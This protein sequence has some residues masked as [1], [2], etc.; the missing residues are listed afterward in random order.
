MRH[1]LSALIGTLSHHRKLMSSLCVICSLDFVLDFSLY[2][3]ICMYKKNDNVY[4]SIHRSLCKST[5]TFPFRINSSVSTIQGGCIQYRPS[6]IVACRKQRILLD[7]KPQGQNEEC[8][9]CLI[10]RHYN[11]SGGAYGPF[12]TWNFGRPKIYRIHTKY[13]YISSYTRFQAPLP[14][15]KLH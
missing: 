14:S 9:H 2:L 15:S 5:G 4:M 10:T 3:F 11:G 1:Q 7:M 12:K 6:A 8:L 13:V